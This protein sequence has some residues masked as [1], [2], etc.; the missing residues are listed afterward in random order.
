M[1]ATY[2]FDVSARFLPDRDVLFVDIDDTIVRFLESPLAEGDGAFLGQS[3]LWLMCKE[4]ERRGMVFQKAQRV[5]HRM[6]NS[7]RWWDWADFIR[8][9]DLDPV[10]FWQTAFEVE[11]RYLGPVCPELPTCFE[12]LKLAGFKMFI[13]SNNPST[14]SLHKLRIAGLGEVWGSPWFQRCFGPPEIHCMKNT[15]EF[16]HRVLAH[17]GLDAR[18]I[19]VIGDSV[20]DDLESSRQA[21]ITSA[22]HF[23]RT[24]RGPPSQR[25]GVWVAGSWEQI[26]HMLEGNPRQQAE[27]LVRAD[28]VPADPSEGPV[29]ASAASD[30]GETR[31]ATPLRSR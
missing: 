15:P 24:H 1:N 18:R 11:R 28:A 2:Y 26:T 30:R 8:A 23:D 20:L 7:R 29:Q 9:L 31:E 4:A 17:T 5:V 16:W 27:T 22:I 13:T 19:T 14:G 12:R 21:G 25:E 6:Y 10:C 3:L